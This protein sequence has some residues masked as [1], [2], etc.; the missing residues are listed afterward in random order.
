MEQPFDSQEYILQKGQ[1]SFHYRF[2]IPPGLRP[3][4]TIIFFPCNKSLGV[5]VLWQQ[6]NK[7]QKPESKPTANAS[8]FLRAF[9]IFRIEH[10]VRR[11]L[12][13]HFN[14]FLWFS[15]LCCWEMNERHAFGTF[16]HADAFHK[17]HVLHKSSRIDYTYTTHD[18]VQP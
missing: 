1:D 6:K 5:A 10:S 2:P 11:R 3:S 17:T 4:I 15:K 14:E 16:V 8:H 7:C 18:Q 13:K 9:S 12:H